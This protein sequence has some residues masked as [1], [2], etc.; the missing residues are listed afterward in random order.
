MQWM[1]LT[2]VVPCHSLHAPHHAAASPF[3]P[4]NRSNDFICP[5]CRSRLYITG[6]GKSRYAVFVWLPRFCF[7]YHTNTTCDLKL[8]KLIVKRKKDL[9]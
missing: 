6:T 9:L 8:Y 4:L 7:E 5:S 2:S 3:G 1:T